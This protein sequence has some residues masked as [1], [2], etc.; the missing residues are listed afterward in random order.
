[1]ALTYN[2][3]T[4]GSTVAN[5]PL[6]V[7]QTIGGKFPWVTSGTT[8]ATVEYGSGGKIWFYSSTNL[9]TDLSSTAQVN[10]FSDGIALG[11]KRGD[12]LIGVQTSAG[13][14][15]PTLFLGVISASAASTGFSLTT[16][17]ITSTYA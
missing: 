9:C 10:A 1:M 13:S 7:A 3:S 15:S 2:G 12:V 17:Y 8:D 4:A 6:V 14:T 16:G 5:P 11:M